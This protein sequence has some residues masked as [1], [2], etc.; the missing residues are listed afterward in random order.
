VDL[1]RVDYKFWK[2]WVTVSAPAARQ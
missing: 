1:R 2:V